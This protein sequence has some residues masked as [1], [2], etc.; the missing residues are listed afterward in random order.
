MSFDLTPERPTKN[1]R[2]EPHERYDV[3][4]ALGRRRL[5]FIFS[6]TVQEVAIK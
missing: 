4:V 6:V 2:V 5:F 3:L 1:R